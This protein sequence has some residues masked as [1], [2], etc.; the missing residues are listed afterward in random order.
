MQLTLAFA[1]AA[2]GIEVTRVF[3]FPVGGRAGR[4]DAPAGGRAVI[5]ARLGLKLF[6]IALAGILAVAPASRSFAA[7]LD[8]F[9]KQFG[10]RAV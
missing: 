1:L 10:D 8:E 7:E 5:L 6:A 3:L 9:F 4:R 2:K